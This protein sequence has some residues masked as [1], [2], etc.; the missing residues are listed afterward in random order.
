MLIIYQF[1]Q[2]FW[3]K[4]QKYGQKEQKRQVSLPKIKKMST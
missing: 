3:M 4:V 1:E 2:Y